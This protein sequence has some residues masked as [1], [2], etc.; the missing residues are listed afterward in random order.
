MIRPDLW[1]LLILSILVSDTVLADGSIIDKIY[2]PY[3]QPLERDIEFRAILENPGKSGNGDSNTY[4]LG[5]GRSFSDSLYGELYLVGT[6]DSGSGLRLDAYEAELKWQLTEQGEYSADWGLLFEYEKMRDAQISEFSTA[7]L[8]EKEWRDWSATAN[9]YAIYE[10]GNDIQSELE[11][12]LNLQARY[13]YSRSLEPAIELYQGQNTSAL[14][15]VLIGTHALGNARKL[16]WEAGMIAG[17]DEQTPDLT[18]KF[19]LEY[20]Y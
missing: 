19:L 20:E 3:V 4:R 16:Y 1:G 8:V 18:L 15:P 17:L 7:L 2:H 14:G 13:R 10:F 5:L 12:A 6:E 9:L 11:S